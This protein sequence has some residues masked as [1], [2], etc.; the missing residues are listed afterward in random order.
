MAFKVATEFLAGLLV[1]GA[2]G[3]YLDD[4]LGTRPVL[5]LLFFALGAAAG[6]LNVIRQAYRMNRELQG[7]LNKSVTDRDDPAG[8]AGKR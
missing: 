3:W 2:I 1:G 8:D 4:W 6:I 7:E 5:F